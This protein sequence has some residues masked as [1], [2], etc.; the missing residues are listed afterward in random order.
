MMSKISNKI[1]DKALTTNAPI[2][3]QVVH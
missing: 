1:I 2:P 3:Q